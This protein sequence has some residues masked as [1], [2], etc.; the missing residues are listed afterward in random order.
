MSSSS[1]NITREFDDLS[2]KIDWNF[3]RNFYST[4]DITPFSISSNIS[5]AMLAANQTRLNLDSTDPTQIMTNFTFTDLFLS[6]VTFNQ[7]NV[8]TAWFAAPS[9]SAQT[10]LQ[11]KSLNERLLIY[12]NDTFERSNS[13]SLVN[14]FSDLGRQI[15]NGTTNLSLRISQ[16]EESIQKV[17]ELSDAANR[18]AALLQTDGKALANIKIQEMKQ[19]IIGVGAAFDKLIRDGTSCKD[20]AID[21]KAIQNSVCHVVMGGLDSVWFA[22]FFTALSGIFSIP[23]F[24]LAIKTFEKRE[25]Q[26]VHVISF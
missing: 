6:D 26:G 23:V 8:D 2:E 17:S 5:V 12:L 25:H 4:N 9:G 24:L 7:E 3:V 21:A 10:V 1:V 22:Y 18:T 16:L 20:I 11:Y 19:V 15:A 14:Q 13:T